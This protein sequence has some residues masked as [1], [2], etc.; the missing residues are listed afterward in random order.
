LTAAVWLIPLVAA[1]VRG[2]APEYLDTYTTTVTD[3]LDL[4]ILVPALVVAAALVLRRD[5]VGYVLRAALLVLLLFVAAA[6]IGGTL[7]Q[8]GAAS[9][10]RRRDCR[11]DRWVRRARRRRGRCPRFAATRGTRVS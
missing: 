8:L 1:V 9:S 6:I 2:E 5:G 7:F 11:S 4:G 3:V 10:T